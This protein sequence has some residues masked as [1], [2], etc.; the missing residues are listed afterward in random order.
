MT[1]RLKILLAIL[2]FSLIAQNDTLNQLVKGK[3]N[4]TWQVYLDSTLNQVD[5]VDSAFFIAFENYD[6]GD[7]IFKYY[8]KQDRMDADSVTFSSNWPTKGSPQVLSGVFEWYTRDGKIINHEE[9]KNGWPRYWKSYIYYKNEPQKCGINEVMDW[10]KQYNNMKGTYYYV[11]YWDSE[12]H[13]HGWFRKGKRGWR[14]YE[15]KKRG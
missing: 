8:N 14:I 4:G 10:S 1:K 12:I 13:L 2:P 7:C 15:E 6:L 3:K 5:V 11:V 9:Y